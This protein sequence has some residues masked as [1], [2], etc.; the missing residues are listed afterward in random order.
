MNIVLLILFGI[1]F[2]TLICMG[3]GGSN[4][5]ILLLTFFLSYSQKSAQTLSLI[6]FIPIA[7]IV[8]IIHF[9]GKMM[10][11]KYLPYFLIIGGVFAFG[12]SFVA[13]ALP[14]NI[15][16]LIYAG[17]LIIAGIYQMISVFVSKNG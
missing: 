5:L 12:F 7:I 4:I 1:L 2:G 6:A 9:K 16:R 15:L 11:K 8:I 3:L 13:N 17:F 10:D 14:D